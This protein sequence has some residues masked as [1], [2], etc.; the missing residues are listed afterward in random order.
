M[1]Q[2]LQESPE[3]TFADFNERLKPI[4]TALIAE[5][6][7]ERP[8]PETFTLGQG[9]WKVFHAPHITGLAS[10][11]GARVDPL[12]YQLEGNDFVSNARYTHPLLGRGW[13]SASGAL[14][15]SRPAWLM[16]YT[17]IFVRL[18]VTTDTRQHLCEVV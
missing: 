14:T 15:G 11:L 12:V 10:A 2:I 8:G 17:N 18:C 4:V 9:D 6:P 3:A 1:L 7:C 13:L 5:N 16:P